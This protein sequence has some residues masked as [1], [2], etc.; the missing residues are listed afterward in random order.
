MSVLNNEF[1]TLAAEHMH[2][3][4]ITPILSM[5]DLG[6]ATIEH[7]DSHVVYAYLRFRRHC[8]PIYLHGLLVDY[9]RIIPRTILEP[10]D[11]TPPVIHGQPCFVQ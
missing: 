11:P 5:I 7:H 9:P 1:K 8:N 4:R 6:R 3:A 2:N 10:P